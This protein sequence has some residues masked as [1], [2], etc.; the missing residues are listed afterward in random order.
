MPRMWLIFVF[1]IT[2]GGWVM[3]YAINQ[4]VRIHFQVDGEGIPLVRFF[5]SLEECCDIPEFLQALE[6]NY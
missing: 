2:K 5:G 3:P 6:G 1:V 4:G